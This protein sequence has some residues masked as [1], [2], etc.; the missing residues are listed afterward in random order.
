M[1]SNLIIKNNNVMT[2]PSIGQTNSYTVN[3]E[4]Q[5][6]MINNNYIEPLNKLYNIEISNPFTLEIGDIIELHI[7]VPTHILGN[8]IGYNLNNIVD[9]LKN[10]NLVVGLKIKASN[11]CLSINLSD[12]T[13][14]KV[15]NYYGWFVFVVTYQASQELCNICNIS[16]NICF[17]KIKIQQLYNK[18]KNTKENVKINSSMCMNLVKSNISSIVN[19]TVGLQFVVTVTLD[20]DYNEFIEN[21]DIEQLRTNLINDYANRF[22]IDPSLIQ[23]I[24]T[25]G[26][27][28]VNYYVGSSAESG[29]AYVNSN[30]LNET[31]Y[32][33]YIQNNSLDTTT[34]LPIVSVSTVDKQ[35]TDELLVEPLFPQEFSSLFL[36]NDYYANGYNNSLINI[37]NNGINFEISPSGLIIPNN[38]S[39]K[40]NK[41]TS[42]NFIHTQQALDWSLPATISGITFQNILFKDLRRFVIKDIKYNGI[43]FDPSKGFELFVR[44]YVYASSDLTDTSNNYSWYGSNMLLKRRATQEEL[45]AGEFVFDINPNTLPKLYADNG[46][47][48]GDSLTNEDYN[49]IKIRDVSSVSFQTNSGYIGPDYNFSFKQ[50]ILYYQKEGDVERS[51]SNYYP[52]IFAP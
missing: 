47:T 3:A 50:S 23:I 5:C 30:Q 48:N 19:N 12:I 33:T 29:T 18:N 27:V 37:N 28:K 51:L 43:E 39:I 42:Y 38:T 1:N 34:Y 15:N 26:S 45:D 16:Y 52:N 8:T 22:N 17:D 44:I 46:N 13:N 40:L 41:I 21:I 14:V 4:N 7:K 25:E 20:I 36:F 32:Q 2:M 9:E 10:N 35:T 6:F 11:K 24:F 31:D 49:T